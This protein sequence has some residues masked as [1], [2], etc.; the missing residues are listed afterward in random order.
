MT[1]TS[2]RLAASGVV[3]TAG[4]KGKLCGYAIKVGTT[5]SAVVE[6]RDGGVAGTVLWEDGWDAVTAAGDIYLRHSFTVPVGFETDI[7]CKFTGT[8]TVVSVSY[9]EG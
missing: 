7:Y 2:K 8:G 6:F 9:I 1:A 4:V 3:T 5:A